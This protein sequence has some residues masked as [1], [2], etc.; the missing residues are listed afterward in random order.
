MRILPYTDALAPDFAAINIGW[1]E[2]MFVLEPHDRHVLAHPREAIV[3]RGGTILFAAAEDGAIIGTGALMPSDPGAVELTKMGVLPA[4]RGTGAGRALL[5]ALIAAARDMPGIQTL[6]LLTSHKCATAIR[7]Y[8]AAGFVHD[9][10]IM[11]RYGAGYARCD[12]AM[13]Y[14]L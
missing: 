14:P 9:A 1:I 4:A 13:R 8:E 10:D 2:D 7:L 6:Y 5:A 11:A 12:V 3:A